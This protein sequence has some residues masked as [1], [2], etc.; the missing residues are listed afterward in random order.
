M[1]HVW[2]CPGDVADR[3]ERN[4]HLGGPAAFEAAGAHLPHRVPVDVRVALVGDDLIGEPAERVRVE[5]VAVAAIV[6]RVEQHAEHVVLAQLIRVAPQF[7]GRPLLRRHRRRSILPRHVDVVVV[8]HHPGFGPLG[9][10]ARRSAGTVWMKP[11]I[12]G[13][14]AVD[15]LVEPAVDAQR[16][17]QVNRAHDDASVLAA[18]NHLRRNRRW[19][20]LIQRTCRRGTPGRA[21]LRRCVPPSLRSGQRARL[22][23]RIII[24]SG[25]HCRMSVRALRTADTKQSCDKAATPDAGSRT[26]PEQPPP[27]MAVRTDG[28]QKVYLDSDPIWPRST[29]I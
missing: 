3:L 15:R 21:G 6:K 14:V 9:G 8:E 28:G 25:R 11:L 23:D 17:V 26:R 1:P 13:T 27:R 12:G 20:I 2:F 22:N 10:R 4:R 18:R 16:L 19:R 24:D 7:V 5:V 29:R